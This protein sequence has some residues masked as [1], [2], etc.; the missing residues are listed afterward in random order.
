M[1]YP[2]DLINRA[3]TI[4]GH[5]TTIGDPQEGTEEARVALL[6]YTDTLDWLLMQKDWDFARQAATLGAPVKTAPP[7]GY[8]GSP[9]N[10][11]INPPPPWIYEY[12]YPV[13][14]LWVRSVRPVPILIPSFTPYFNNFV[15]AYDA[16]LNQKVVL[17]NLANA[18]V[19]FT[20]QIADP[21]EWQNN[22]FLE[23]FVKQL[24]LRLKAAFEKEPPPQKGQP[25]REGAAA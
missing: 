11:A 15:N 7:G 12:I 3:L 2:A 21:N 5:E 4:I 14:C 13:N 22:V 18:Q 16:Q 24:A 9:W 6:H 8:G 20:A 1:I 23:E 10:Q 19:V 17:T 25:Q